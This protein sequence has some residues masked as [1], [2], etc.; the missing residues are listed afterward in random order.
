MARIAVTKSVRMGS[1]SL[2]A[3]FFSRGS[4]TGEAKHIGGGKSSHD[5]GGGRDVYRTHPEPSIP[6]LDLLRAS[7]DRPDFHGDDCSSYQGK[8]TLQNQ[9]QYP[10]A[11]Q[12]PS[13]SNWGNKILFLFYEPTGPYFRQIEIDL[14]TPSISHLAISPA[15]D[16]EDNTPRE[17]ISALPTILSSI[18]SV[19]VFE[20][21]RGATCC[22]N[23]PDAASIIL[24]AKYASDVAVP[25]IRAVGS[26]FPID[27]GSFIT[28]DSRRKCQIYLNQTCTV[29]I[30]NFDKS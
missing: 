13:G 1:S 27:S 2:P 26:L 7:L 14:E 20:V 6:G 21:W 23:G 5:R 30:S 22:Q 19:V 24:D 15:A 18:S 11:I 16:G 25:A 9:P 10:F 8:S 28:S 3:D 12:F 17:P 29:L 4:L